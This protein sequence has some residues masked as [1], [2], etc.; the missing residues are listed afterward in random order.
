MGY[1]KQY[2]LYYGELH[3]VNEDENIVEIKLPNEHFNDFSE[4]TLLK[5]VSQYNR[6]NERIAN[7]YFNLDLIENGKKVESATYSYSTTYDPESYKTGEFL[8]PLKLHLDEKR[9]N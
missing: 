7:I 3:L 4:E 8:K 6:G 5:F 1:K 9:L 2:H